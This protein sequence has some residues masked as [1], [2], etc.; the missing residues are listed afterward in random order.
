M[1]SDTSYRTPRTLLFAALGAWVFLV[2]FWLIAAYSDI[3]P[4]KALPEPR[5]VDVKNL[6]TALKRA[7]VDQRTPPGARFTEVCRQGVRVCTYR[8]PNKNSPTPSPSTPY[9]GYTPPMRTT[10]PPMPV[11]APAGACASQGSCAGGA[12]CPTGASCSGYP[13]YSCF[14][15]GCAYIL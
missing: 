2:V 11:Q 3:L 15:P 4:A 8:L 7:C 5:A 1:R 13:L 10:P 6:C 12:A 14:P 9:S